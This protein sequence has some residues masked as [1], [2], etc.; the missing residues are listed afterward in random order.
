MSSPARSWSETTIACASLNCSRYHRSTIAVSSGRPHMFIVYQRGRGHEPVTVAGSIR[1]FVA[2]NAMRCSFPR[3]RPILRCPSCLQ[4]RDRRPRAGELDDLDAVSVRVVDIETLAAIVR[5][6]DDGH[7]GGRTE[8]RP[9]R[10][11]PLVLGV[12]VVGHEAEMGAAR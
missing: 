9:E 7:G 10:L 4:A 11:Q 5:P 3:C 2:V 12:E 1:S 8:A 6:A